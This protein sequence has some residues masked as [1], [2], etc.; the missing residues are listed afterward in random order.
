MVERR[1]HAED[2]RVA[3]KSVEPPPPTMER[4]PQAVDG[5]EVAQVD[6]HKRHETGARPV[7]A[8]GPDRRVPPD[9][10]ECGREPRHARRIGPKQ[11]LPR[12]QCRERPRSPARRGAARGLFRRVQSTLL[13]S[14]ASFVRSG[15][16]R[17]PKLGDWH[18]NFTAAPRVVGRKRGRRRF[19]FA[20]TIGSTLM[21]CR[22][23]N[24]VRSRQ[25]EGAGASL[26]VCAVR[27]RC[28]AAGKLI[29]ARDGE[30][31]G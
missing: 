10:L 4:F 3:D 28:A 23:E 16:G 27:G 24:K 22:S 2:A 15:K 8:L 12:G 9:P 5:G 1:Q 25:G 29:G 20:P 19:S 30:R 31:K 26:G 7:G 14:F 21:D 6:R 11:P 17:G 18:P 13:G